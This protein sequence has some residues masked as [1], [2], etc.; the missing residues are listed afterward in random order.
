ME[1]STLWQYLE[2]IQKRTPKNSMEIPYKN[3]GGAYHHQFNVTDYGQS[4]YFRA[5][6][7]VEL[8]WKS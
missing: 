2:I 3:Y 8:E 7:L 5:Y 4:E 6:F 1:T